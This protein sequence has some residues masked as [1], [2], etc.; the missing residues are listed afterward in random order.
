MTSKVS[1]LSG[2]GFLKNCHLVDLIFMVFLLHIVCLFCSTAKSGGQ[3][4]ELKKLQAKL[5]QQTQV[6]AQELLN[7]KKTLSDAE[8]NN[9]R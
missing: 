6:S 5:E 7:V 9:N 8:N 4:E 3:A 1:W 2:R